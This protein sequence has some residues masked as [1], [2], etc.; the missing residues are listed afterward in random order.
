MEKSCGTI[1]F[2]DNRVLMV[3]QNIG[4]WSFP[5]GH[6]EDGET[7]EDTAIRE[8]YEETGVKVK[9]IDVNNNFSMEY[10]IKN[11]LKKVILFLAEVIDDKNM[12]PQEIEISQVE[13]IEI[14]KVM[15][16][17]TYDNSK[18]LWGKVLK[19]IE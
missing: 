6:V 9:I 18:K 19:N 13:W 14:D 4:N 2:K 8:T 16:L 7:E 3:K 17:L 15:D 12:R 5:K 11:H 10:P 1:T